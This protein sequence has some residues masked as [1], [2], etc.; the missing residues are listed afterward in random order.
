MLISI[1]YQEIQLCTDSDKPRMIFSLLINVKMPT[2][3]GI[4]TLMSRKNSCSIE[5]SMKKFYKLG[6]GFRMYCDPCFRELVLVQYSIY[7]SV[8]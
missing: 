7:K 3:V 6:A 2:S 4:L 8:L 1:K 5:L